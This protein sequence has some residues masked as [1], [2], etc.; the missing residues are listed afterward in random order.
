MYKYVW[1]KK[2]RCR[3]RYDRLIDSIYSGKSS[4][5]NK[6]NKLQQCNEKCNWLAMVNLL[7]SPTSCMCVRMPMY[8]LLLLS[9]SVEIASPTIIKRSFLFKNNIFSLWFGLFWWYLCDFWNH[10]SK[11]SANRDLGLQNDKIK[12]QQFW[13]CTQFFKWKKNWSRVWRKKRIK[14]IH[15]IV[16]HFH[17]LKW[18]SLWSFSYCID[19]LLFFFAKEIQIEMKNGIYLCIVFMSKRILHHVSYR[20]KEIEEKI[21]SAMCVKC[22]CILKW[23]K[24]LLFVQEKKYWLNREKYWIG[25]GGNQTNKPISTVSKI[26]K[27]NTYAHTFWSWSLI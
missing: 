1:L 16:D 9:I 19:C 3:C 27:I 6:R 17:S 11:S 15:Y 26:E 24:D 10:Y 12:R 22:V 23:K 21:E 25:G 13:R 8:L 7:S 18:R 5:L 2:S 4:M 14:L 20:T